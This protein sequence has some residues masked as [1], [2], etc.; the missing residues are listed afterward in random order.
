M[1][2]LDKLD[3]DKIAEQILKMKE[4]QDNQQAEVKVEEVKEVQVEAPKPTAEEEQRNR[5]LALEKAQ[6]EAYARAKAESETK[7]LADI[8]TDT[9]KTLQTK[10]NTQLATHIENNKE[11]AKKIENTATQLVDKGLEVQSN[12]ATAKIIESEDEILEADYKKYKDEYLYHGIDHKIDKAWKKRL[13]LTIN[14]IWFVIWAIISCFTI[15]PVS[16]FL[17]RIKALS[18]FIKGV[19]VTLGVILLLG[20]LFGL[21]VLVLNKCGVNIFR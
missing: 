17:S 1:E 3:L 4:T 21:T 8:V 12:S 2:N 18:G 5:E 9:N 13:I 19:A 6:A 11:V 20:C 14:N 10:L 7:A 15:V 16:T